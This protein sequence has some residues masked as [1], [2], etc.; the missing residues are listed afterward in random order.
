MLNVQSSE[1][2][3]RIISYADAS[4]NRSELLLVSC[5]IRPSGGVYLNIDVQDAARVAEHLDAVQAELTAF[6]A[7]AF[8]RASSMGL[9][10]PAVG[11]GGNA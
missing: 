1:N 3:S 11:G 10:V 2:P 9:P 4:G 5:N 6:V 7:E 8:A